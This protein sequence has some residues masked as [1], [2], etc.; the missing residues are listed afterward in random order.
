MWEGG[1]R[2]PT[3]IQWPTKIPKGIE[4]DNIAATIDILPTLAEITGAPLPEK[5]IDGVSILPLLTA[6]EG[7]RPR[8][9]YLF[10]YYRDLIAV[11]K[12][13]WKL[14]FPHT[15]RSYETV[16]PGKDGFPGPYAIGKTM[17]PELYNLDKDINE[18]KNLFNEYPEIV[19]ELDI[20][21]EKARVELGDKLNKIK[22]IEVRPPGR[23]QQ[24]L[25]KADHLAIGKKIEVLSEYNWQ[26]SGS[27]D[28]TLIN[29]ILGSFDYSDDQWLGFH[30]ND[31]EAVIDLQEIKPLQKIDCGFLINQG[32]WIFAPEEVTISVSTDGKNYKIAETFRQEAQAK[33]KQDVTRLS[34]F[35]LDEEAR[36][37]KV[38]AKGVN[39]CPEWHIGR[40]EKA[41][42]FVDEIVIE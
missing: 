29:G 28:S 18:S 25:K 39:T 40:G 12:D 16:E 38:F 30:G 24:K 36:Y 1:P 33:A 15:Y 8:D 41:W 6:Q 10:Y 26:Y 42:L 9:N 21:A 13:N 2:V 35:F 37:I 20:I 19:E 7:A 17:V 22:G 5:K 27:G 11:R 14:V 3:V 34:A 4:S 23:I 31:F 32:S